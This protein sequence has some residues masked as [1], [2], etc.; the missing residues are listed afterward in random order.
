MHRKHPTYKL[1]FKLVTII[2]HIRDSA[3]SLR[4][5]SPEEHAYGGKGAKISSA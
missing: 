5:E 4:S 2:S 1:K 3:E